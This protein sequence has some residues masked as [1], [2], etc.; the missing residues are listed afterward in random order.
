M[1]CSSRFDFSRPTKCAIYFIPAHSLSLCLAL[2]DADIEARRNPPFS[3]SVFSF[4]FGGGG[5]HQH[6]HTHEPTI[7]PINLAKKANLTFS[8]P[9]LPQIALYKR[10]EKNYY[11]FGFGTV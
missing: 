7:L 5:A 9:R 2:C 11:F 8:A 4:F 3:H 10:T 1:A 6:T